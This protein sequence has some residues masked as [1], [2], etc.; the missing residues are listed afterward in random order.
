MDRLAIEMELPLGDG[1]AGALAR[2]RL[3]HLAQVSGVERSSLLRLGRTFPSLGAVY[4][5]PEPELARV[6]GEVAAAR[7]RW[8]LDAPLSAAVIDPAAKPVIARAA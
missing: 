5:A 4:A 7:I 8:F 3:E 6:V 2:R 1:D